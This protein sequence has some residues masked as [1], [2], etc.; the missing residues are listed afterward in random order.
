MRMVSSLQIAQALQEKK[1]DGILICI[2]AYGK[3][4]EIVDYAQYQTFESFQ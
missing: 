3:F 4:A 1:T 2:F